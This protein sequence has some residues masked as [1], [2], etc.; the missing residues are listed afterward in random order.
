MRMVLSSRLIGKKLII[1]GGKDKGTL[2][3]VY[4]FLEDYLGCRK[5]SSK[6]SF[7]PENPVITLNPVDTFSILLLLTASFIFLIRSMMRII[8]TGISSMQK[9]ERMNGACL[10]ILFKPSFRLKSILKIIL[11]ISPSSM[12]SAFPMGS[13]V[14]PIPMFLIS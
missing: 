5:Y 14:C 13:F 1:A 10:F 7:I 6:V 11:S 12:F 4:T 9:R 8:A 2:Y 3:G